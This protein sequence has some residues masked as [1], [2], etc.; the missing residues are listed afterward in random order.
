MIG[1]NL[2]HELKASDAMNYFGSWAKG[3]RYYE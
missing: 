1:T 2:G 3:F